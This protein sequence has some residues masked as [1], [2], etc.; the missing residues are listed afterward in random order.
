M[1]RQA[2]H[3]GYERAR[4]E[5]HRLLDAASEQDLARPTCGTRWDNRELL[6]HMLFGY[7]VVRSLLGLVRVSGRLPRGVSRVFARLLEGVTVPFDLVNYA[8]PR[9]AVKV[10]SLHRMGVTFDRVTD[11]LHRRLA[12]E[13]ESDLGR[14]MH[15]PVRWDPFF[16]DFMTLADVYRYPTQHFEFHRRQLT[17]SGPRQ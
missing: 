9:G 7:L 6:W 13:P 17:L 14:G 12:A 3:D 11:S 10:F 15:F 16:A 2:V 8:G 5:F 4:Q 1:D